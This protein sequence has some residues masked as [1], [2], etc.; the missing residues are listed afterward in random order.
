GIDPGDLLIQR[1]AQIQ[2]VPTVTHHNAKQQCRLAIVADQESRRIFVTP[3]HLGDIRQL[4]RPPMSNNRCVANLLQLVEGA[5]QANEDL[6][7]LS[8]DRTGRGEKI[9]AVECREDVLWRNAER[10]QAIM[11]KGHEG[12]FGPFADQVDLLYA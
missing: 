12:T 1:L 2:A 9:L 7:S 11:G 6:W 5:V 3:L 10:R 4:E 8:V